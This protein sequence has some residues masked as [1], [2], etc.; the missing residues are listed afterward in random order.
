MNPKYISMITPS[1]WYVGGK[2]LDNFREEMLSDSHLREI[3]DWL[4][5]EDI[6]PNTNIRGGVCYFLL[7]SSY[8]NKSGGTRVFTYEENEIVSDTVR[9]LKYN[10]SGI[11]VRDSKAISILEK[12]EY[13]ENNS[14]MEYVSARNPFGF[15]TNFTKDERFKNDKSIMTSPVKCYANKGIIGYIEENEI[16]KNFE[17]IG[18]RK[19]L[20]PYS[21][22]IGTELSDDNLNTVIAT[23]NSICTETY[24]VIGAKLDLDEEATENLSKYLKTKF[25]RFLHS[26]AKSSQH[27]TRNTYRFVSLQDFSDNNVVSW[28]ESAEKINMQLYR[29]YNLTELEIEHIENKI[30]PMN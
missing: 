8:D 19:V 30:K 15:S 3:H 24:L 2:G 13:G 22:N 27:G 5:P 20:T 4:T 26:L 7:D 23:S 9:T 12:I 17:W 29:K 18:K 11:F 25:V 10:D 1:R 28:A 6:F 14:L 16:K 21:N